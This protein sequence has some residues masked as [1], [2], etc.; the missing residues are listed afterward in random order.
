VQLVLILDCMSCQSAIFQRM[1]GACLRDEL[2]LWY[3][4]LRK[5]AIVFYVA[6]D[7]IEA[8]N[9]PSNTDEGEGDD[10]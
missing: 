8:T 3:Y 10:E 2:D 5:E 4:F 9:G 1:R 6:N 7:S